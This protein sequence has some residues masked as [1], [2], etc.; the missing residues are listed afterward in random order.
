MS[1]TLE[2]HHPYLRYLKKA[3]GQGLLYEDKGNVK[4]PGT[5]MLIGQASLLTDAL[6]WNIVSS[7]EE[8]LSLGKVRSIKSSVS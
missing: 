6:L 8:M 4:S 5:V 2:C 7:L 3:P 1:W